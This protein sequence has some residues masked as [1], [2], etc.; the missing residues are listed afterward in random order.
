MNKFFTILAGGAVFAVSAIAASATTLTF[1]AGS[2]APFSSYTESGYKVTDGNYYIT[3]DAGSMHFDISGGPYSATRTI[4]AISGAVFSVASLDIGSIWPNISLGGLLGP[5]MANI[6]FT[7][8]L[9]GVSVAYAW[10]SSEIGNNTFNFG[11]AFSD[12]DTFTIAGFS[13][14]NVNYSQGID[15]HF[16]I[17]N[18]VLAAVPLPA[19]ALMLGAA[20]GGLGFARRRRKA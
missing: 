3:A 19:S 5:P 10:G 17:D 11:S 8:F 1:D 9:G 4:S 16:T 12:I 2:G 15:V 20:L 6:S 13:S 14:G 7:G 18:I